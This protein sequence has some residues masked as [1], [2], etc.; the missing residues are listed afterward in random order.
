MNLI[1]KKLIKYGKYEKYRKSINFLYLLN[2]PKK[3]FFNIFQHRIV[4]S[5]LF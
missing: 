4:Q 2:I 3:I 5:Y 1:V